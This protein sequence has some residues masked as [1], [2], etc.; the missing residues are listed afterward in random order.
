[1]IAVS[2]SDLLLIVVASLLVSSHAVHEGRAY[3]RLASQ[4]LPRY[5]GSYMKLVNPV[6][7]WV[8]MCLGE[9]CDWASHNSES[10]QNTVVDP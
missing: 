9:T 1:M 6:K 7:Q 2:C 5:L 8:D 10:A 4:L 3:R